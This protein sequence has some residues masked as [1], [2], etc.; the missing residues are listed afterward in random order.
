MLRNSEQRA[1]AAARRATTSCCVQMQELQRRVIP[2]L[3]AGLAAK[4]A[5]CAGM[6]RR[7]PETI[8]LVGHLCPRVTQRHDAVEDEPARGRVGVDGEIARPLELHLLARAVLRR[9]GLEGALEPLVERVRV[10]VAQK[11]AVLVAGARLGR[12]EQAVVQPDG[13]ARGVRLRDPVDDA[14]DLLPVGHL[15]PHR[16]AGHVRAAQLDRLAVLPA[17]DLVELQHV[18]EPE[19]DLRA[20]ALEAK[21][22][23]VCELVEVGPLDEQRAR[24]GTLPHPE[25]RPLGVDRPFEHLHLALRPARHRHAQRVEHRHHARRLRVERRAHAILEHRVVD[26]VERLAHACPVDEQTDRLRRNASPPQPDESRHARVVPARDVPLAHELDQLPLREHAVLQ[27]EPRELDLARGAGHAGRVC[28]DPVVERSVRLEL[29][30]A[31]RVRDAFQRIRE[32]VRKVVHRV[33]LPLVPSLRVGGGP[34]DAV[35]GRV[36]QV[37]VRARHV[38]LEP[39]DGGAVLHL[40]RRHRAEERDALLHRPIAEGRVAAGRGERA[41]VLAHLLRRQLVHVCQPLAHQ[42]LRVR[43]ELL[44]VVAGVRQPVGPVKAEPAHVRENGVDVLALLLLRVGVV[45]PHVRPPAKLLAQA[46]VDADALCV[47]DVEVAVWLGREAR[48]DGGVLSAAEVR[49]DDVAHKVGLLNLGRR[50]GG[51]GRHA[52]GVGPPERPQRAC[53]SEAAHARPAGESSHRRC[54]SGEEQ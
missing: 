39:H 50:G 2:T 19:P 42:L 23:F 22:L 7:E 30:G 43:V 26:V 27:V 13:G 18:P 40:P 51:G 17:H 47:A 5:V 10:E 53:C 24:E 1:G 8:S 37:D 12:G 48:H 38:D 46:K 6:A 34:L 21:V 16:G 45:E 25:L 4:R 35:D 28:D 54:S 52:A 32:R 15:A 29:G 9:G 3:S 31:E 14:L 20:D 33:D 49:L 44:K 36:A 41:A 11:V